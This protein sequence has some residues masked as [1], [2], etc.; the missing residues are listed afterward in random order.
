[1]TDGVPAAQPGLER[2]AAVQQ[3]LLRALGRN[4]EEGREAAAAG[5]ALTRVSGR[6]SSPD[7]AISV[8]VDSGGLPK[9]IRFTDRIAGRSPQQLAAELMGCIQ[10]AQAA[11]AG[12]FAQQAGENP[13]AARIAEKYQSRFPQPAPEHAAGKSNEMSIGALSEQEATPAPPPAPPRRAPRPP[14]PE[15]E[16]DF[17]Q[18]DFLQGPEDRGRHRG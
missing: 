6:A 8:V 2:L 18:T 17:A 3:D 12:E 13:F 7:N 16:E 11:L 4:K 9:D 1:M 14:T 10:R 15:D 5:Q